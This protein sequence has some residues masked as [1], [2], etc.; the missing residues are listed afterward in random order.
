MVYTQNTN[1]RHTDALYQTRCFVMHAVWGTIDQ[2][3]CSA[4]TVQIYSNRHFT[5]RLPSF[6]CKLAAP[7]DL[8][9]SSAPFFGTS[10]GNG[11]SLGLKYQIYRVWY[12]CCGRYLNRTA[13]DQIQCERI[14]IEGKALISWLPVSVLTTDRR[15]VGGLIISL[16]TLDSV[17]RGNPLSSISSSS[18]YTMTTLSLMTVS[19][20]SP[21]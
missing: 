11:Q 7:Q 12:D 3:S 10:H 4:V 18:S 17:A 14:K 1:D 19:E 15:M 2:Q 8:K 16:R 20:H 13:L 6:Y 21:K 5:T 9:K